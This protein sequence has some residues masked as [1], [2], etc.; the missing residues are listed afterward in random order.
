M[1]ETVLSC[2]PLSVRSAK[3]E[4]RRDVADRSGVG[5]T[6][7]ASFRLQ[8]IAEAASMELLGKTLPLEE[9]NGWFKAEGKGIFFEQTHYT[10]YLDLPKDAV[11]ARLFSPLA[12]LCESADWD[13]RIRR[14]TLPL[15]FGNNLG[16][17]EIRWEWQDEAGDWHSG[18]L[19]SQ[20]LSYKL[21]VQ[22]HFKSMMK[23]VND[24][25]KWIH[26]DLLRQTFWGWDRDSN[27]ESSLQTWLAIFQEVRLEMTRGFETLTEKHRRRLLPD[28]QHLRADRI[29][30]MNPRLEERIAEGLKDRPDQRYRVETR[31]LDAD[32]PENRYM[33]HLLG[34]TLATLHAL[35]E[36][37]ARIKRVSD[38]FKERLDEWRGEWESLRQHRFWR[39]IGNFRGL[40]KESLVLSQ[41]PLYAGIR[42]HHFWLQ[43]GLSLLDKELKGGIQ[44]AAQLYEI[45]CLIQLDKYL[46]KSGWE[47]TGENLIDFERGDDD[48][49]NKED[50]RTGTIKMKYS[51]ILLALA[52]I[53]KSSTIDAKSINLETAKELL[54][55]LKSL[56][57]LDDKSELNPK[58]DLSVLPKTLSSAFA[59]QAEAIAKAIKEQ[60]PLLDLLYQPTAN[61]K[62]N[63]EIWG[64][65]MSRPVIQR[66]DMVLR[67]TRRDLP[68]RPV[69]TWIFDAKYQVEDDAAPDDTLNVMHRYRDAIL[70]SAEGSGD[71]TLT[72]ESLGAFVLYPGKNDLEN[73]S[74][75]QFASIEKVNIGAFPLLPEQPPSSIKGKLKEHLDGLLCIGAPATKR[76]D[77]ATHE[78]EYF[79]SVPGAKSRQKRTVARCQ[80]RTYMETMEYW[81]HCPLHRIPVEDVAAAAF[82][83]ED[84]GWIVPH[85]G[86]FGMFPISSFRRM[87]RKDIV[88][89][90]HKRDIYIRDPEATPDKEYWI[91]WLGLRT[92]TPESLPTHPLHKVVEVVLL[93]ESRGAY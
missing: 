90:Y 93:D 12:S 91:F 60:A 27:R 64:G 67:L 59:P 86:S 80:V 54:T 24:R 25:F 1:A 42:R 35:I 52:A 66:P 28:E 74:Q 10:L 3:A 88:E 56:S 49:A 50:V 68:H 23:D 76:I 69:Y 57:V 6:L 32:T 5:I 63:S 16:D 81:Q 51:S 48:F 55:E 87:K 61:D 62:P 71:G 45:W 38:V 82:P 4:S 65:M 78:E 72:R 73:K 37:L 79:K 22:T 85:D 70:W 19:R 34:Q 84:W 8:G 31:H 13:R 43:E 36:R 40:R 21:D 41:D 26:L 15:N 14:L 92:T 30:K 9:D 2:G 47:R 77:W 46:E 7:A 58:Y 75:D 11:E 18:A 89:L 29:R 33:K 83:H 39:G 17:F 20:V 53:F 44:N